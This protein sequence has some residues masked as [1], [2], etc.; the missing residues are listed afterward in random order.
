MQAVGENNLLCC[1]HQFGKTRFMHMITPLVTGLS[2]TNNLQVP[3][4][5]LRLT[6]AQLY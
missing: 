1:P 2:I 3:F 6:D 5:S 4:I